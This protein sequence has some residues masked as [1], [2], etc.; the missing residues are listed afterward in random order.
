MGMDNY[1]TCTKCENKFPATTEFF[2]KQKTGKFGLHA[3]CKTC[4]NKYNQEYC[5]N[6]P[7][8][9][10]VASKKYYINNKEKC[11]VVAKKYR[12]NNPEKVATW[13]K[14]NKEKNTVA[15]KKYYMN[16]KGKCAAASKK[17][18]EKN[19]ERILIRRAEY[20][21]NNK[22]KYAVNAKKWWE[23]NPDKRNVYETKRR[24]EKLDQSPRLTQDE[25]HQIDLIY[26][27][28]QELGSD[29]QV[30]HVIPLSKGGLHHPGNLQIV[31]KDYNLQKN[32]KIDFRPPTD[33]EIF[34]W[35]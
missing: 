27:K 30:D 5:K 25:K 20:Y 10:A 29:W 7:G 2:Y 11:M 28:S 26:K 18:Y 13:Q 31:T 35:N 32:D 21:A 22:E 15:S 17:Y 6:N 33:K 23:A 16:N 12:V 8:K 3:T 19:K 9:H 34:N 1:K 14:N 4:R 24:A